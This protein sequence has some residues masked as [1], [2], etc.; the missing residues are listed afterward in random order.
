M[1]YL[2]SNGE[3]HALVW[4]FD[5]GV[6]PPLYAVHASVKYSTKTALPSFVMLA[7]FQPNK[8]ITHGTCNAANLGKIRSKQVYVEVEC[9]ILVFLILRVCRAKDLFWCPGKPTG[10]VD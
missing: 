8:S 1:R 3:F 4:L 7:K 10:E 6:K 2:L 9:K 5:G